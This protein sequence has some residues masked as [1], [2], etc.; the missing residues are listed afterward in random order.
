MDPALGPL[1]AVARALGPLV[2]EVVFVGGAIVPVLR[3]R[4]PIPR[5]RPTTDV[6]AILETTRYADLERVHET[7]RARGFREDSEGRHAHRW[8]SPD[9]TAFDLVPIGHHLG[10]LGSDLEKEV[11]A[12]A[13]SHHLAPD[14]TIRHAGPAGFLALKCAAYGH[15]G[16]SDP[17]NSPDLEDL[18][19]VVACR[20]DIVAQVHDAPELLRATVAQWAASIVA[21]P[22]ESDLLAA[23]LNGADDVP[24]TILAVRGRLRRMV[25]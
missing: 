1:S 12:T 24:A 17:L 9:G 16:K 6:D 4:S 10:G 19:A 8:L 13:T 5:V 2:E 23:Y 7:M 18:L 11:V 22:L 14:L 21:D 3:T 20:P 15:R 25:E